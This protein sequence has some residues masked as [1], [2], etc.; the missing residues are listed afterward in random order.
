MDTARLGRGEMIAA[1][2]AIVLLIV[3][4]LFNWFGYEAGAE[5]FSA[6]VG[7]N[8]WE[9]FGFID[10][11]LLITIL[12]AIGL[13]VMAANAQS[14]NLPVA[15]SALVAGLGILSVL[16][17]LFRIISPPDFGVGDFE[18]GDAVDISRKIGVFIGLIAAGGIAYGGFLGMQEEG[19]SFR[20]QGDRLQNRGPTDPPPPAAGG[21]NPP[22]AV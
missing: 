12:V 7:L 10:I 22:P 2:S 15:G 13:A 14:H 4:F 9:S 18:L 17:I 20:E 6:S 5:G 21:G 3:M 8:A 11:V 19:T 16:L 1:V